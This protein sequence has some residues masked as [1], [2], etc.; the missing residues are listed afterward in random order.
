MTDYDILL[1]AI[2]VSWES[3]HQGGAPVGSIVV[4]EQEIIGV[5]VSMSHTLSNPMQHAEIAAIQEAAWFVKSRYLPSATLYTSLEPCLLCLSLCAW[6][7]IPRVMYACRKENVP[8]YFYQGDERIAQGNSRLKFDLE[9][10]HIE[11]LEEQALQPI[12]RYIEIR[13]ANLASKNQEQ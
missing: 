6:A 9:F 1:K 11:T 3:L 8:T 12:M 10:K 2:D 5:G 4:Q 13:K 7:H